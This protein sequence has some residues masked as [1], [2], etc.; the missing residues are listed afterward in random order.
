MEGETKEMVK[1]WDVVQYDK[2]WKLITE[3]CKRW[4]QAVEL[5]NYRVKIDLGVK[6]GIGI[7]KVANKRH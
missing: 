2:S 4:W 6:Y 5:L 1:F 7:D 3:F